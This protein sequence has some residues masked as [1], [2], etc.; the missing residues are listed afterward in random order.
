M[1]P[2]REDGEDKGTLYIIKYLFEAVL[3]TIPLGPH[4]GV[5]VAGLW[6]LAV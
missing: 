4:R 2:H 1:D 6:L 3:G 5:V